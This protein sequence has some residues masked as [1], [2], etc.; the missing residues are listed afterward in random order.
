MS[1]KKFDQKW[2]KNI[3]SKSIYQNLNTL[4]QK[5]EIYIDKTKKK[6][7]SKQKNIKKKLKK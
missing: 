7:Q 6:K 3:N 2:T 5:N 1:K 4:V